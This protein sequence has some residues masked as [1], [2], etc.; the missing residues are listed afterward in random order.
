P[1]KPARDR[2]CLVAATRE[3]WLAN[4]TRI[5]HAPRSQIA[6]SP[7]GRIARKVEERAYRPG[8]GEY[9]LRAPD[10]LY[11]GP[12]SGHSFS[13]P[14]CPGRRAPPRVLALFALVP[15]AI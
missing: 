10:R 2:S 13:M 4:H 11:R 14:G 3:F 1:I 15:A 8:R 7:G 5:R 9:S 12:R 6:L